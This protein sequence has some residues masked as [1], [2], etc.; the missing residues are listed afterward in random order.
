MATTATRPAYQGYLNQHCVT[1]AEVHA[2]GYHTLM[3]GKWH[4]G[5]GRGQ[6]PVD[7]G[8]ERYYGM[9]GGGGNY[10]TAPGPTW[11]DGL[12]GKVTRAGVITI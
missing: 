9:V 2:A 6:W 5:Q 1:L 12:D 10:F 11:T 3:A 4:V 7:R 8:F